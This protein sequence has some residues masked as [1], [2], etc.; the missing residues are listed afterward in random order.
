VSIPL[1]R[2]RPDVPAAPLGDRL[3]VLDAAR[4]RFVGLNPVAAR[5]W[6]LVAT[7]SGL[8]DLVARLLTEFD[9]DPRTCRTETAAVLAD[10][11]AR[12]L[13]EEI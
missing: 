10:L 7:P 6:D 9:V 3:L 8:D 4:G 1:L 11:H 2:R 13:V 12:G 5:I